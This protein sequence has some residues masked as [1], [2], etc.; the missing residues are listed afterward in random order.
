MIIDTHSHL[1]LDTFKEDL[2]QIIERAR[3]KEGESICLPDISGD[4]I[5]AVFALCDEE[6]DLFY[7][8]LGLH[9]VYVKDDYEEE[10]RKIE[11]RLDEREIYAIGEIGSDLYRGREYKKQ[12]EKA[13]QHQCEWALDRDLL[14]VIH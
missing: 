11:A 3:K 14:I 1:Y 4:S 2:D 12:Q 10:L 6:P 7:P 9:P 5:D 8:M 13:V